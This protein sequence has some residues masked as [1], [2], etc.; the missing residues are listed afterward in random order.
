MRFAI[1]GRLQVDRGGEPVEITRTRRPLLVTLLL[2]GSGGVGAE[3]LMQ[4]AWGDT[5]GRQNS[6]KTALS[7]LRRLLPGR[8]PSARAHGYRIALRP[9]D[10]FDLVEFRRLAEE[11][12]ARISTGDQQAA[13]DSLHRALKLWGDPPLADVP[14]DPIRLATWRQELL[15]ERKVAQQDLLRARLKTGEHQELLGDL[16]REL[17]DDPLSEILNALLMT[18][19]YR[20]GYR[21]EALRHYDMLATLL[22]QDTGADP[23]AKLRRLR[24][25]IAADTLDLRILDED[26]PATS[27]T[28]WGCSRV[29][30]AW[31]AAEA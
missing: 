24:D 3:T 7:Q 6:L 28:T 12:K 21:V 5:Y 30:L 2:A 15:W 26:E 25:E 13:V 16:R 14:E 9:G 19:L 27:A 4:A 1:L 23:G 22:A 8:I 17:A 18:A 20:A 10:Q 31:K 11:G 29:C